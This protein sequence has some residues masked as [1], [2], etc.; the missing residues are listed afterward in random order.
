MH[1]FSVIV[2]LFYFSII[3]VCLAGMNVCTILI[4]VTLGGYW[5]YWNTY[6]Q[7]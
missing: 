1:L 2:V 4:L 5:I 6:S 7:L 3:C